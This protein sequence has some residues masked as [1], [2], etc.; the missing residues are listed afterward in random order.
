MPPARYFCEHGVPALALS[1]YSSDE[2]RRSAQERLRSREVNFLFVVDLYNEGVD[3]PEV[4]TVLF[5]RPTDFT[6]WETVRRE[7][8]EEANR[9]CLP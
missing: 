2:D 9:H 1:A 5:L 3:I 4:D 7:A 6:K 8:S